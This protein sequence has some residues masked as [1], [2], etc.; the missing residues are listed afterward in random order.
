MA[1]AVDACGLHTS[2]LVVFIEHMITRTFREL[3]TEDVAEEE[4]VI[5]FML[6]V[7]QILGEDID[8]C[9]IKRHDQRLS[10]LRNVDVHHVVIEIEIL[11]LN[12]HEAPLSNSCAEKEVRHSPALIFSKGAFLDVRF[13]QKQLQLRVGIGFDMVFINLYGLHLEMRNIALIHKEV[14]G[15]D[16]IS[17]IGINTDVIMQG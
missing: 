10:V 9:S 14:Q 8:H 17:Q 13:L 1:V 7:F 5:A 4:V 16:Q 6:S 2:A 15:S 12:V 11:D 3:L